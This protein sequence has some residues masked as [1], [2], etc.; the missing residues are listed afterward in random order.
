MRR[1]GRRLPWRE[2]FNG[3][4]YLG[5]LV[6]YLVASR[7]EGQIQ[8]ATLTT[9]DAL[10]TALLPPLHEPVLTGFAIDAFRLRGFERWEA[11]GSSYSV[12]R[13]WRCTVP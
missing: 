1:R 12:A 2:L 11:A 5:Q 8:V 6:T 3:P 10:C 13:E 7:A 9:G 4:S